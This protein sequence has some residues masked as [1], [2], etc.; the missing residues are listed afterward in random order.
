MNTLWKSAIELTIKKVLRMAHG[1]KILIRAANGTETE[2]DLTELAAINSIAAA[3]LAKIDGITNGTAAAGKALVL[4]ATGNIDTFRMTGKLFTPQAAPETATDT[5]TLTAAQ[6]LSGILV[7]TPTAA[8]AYT[9]LTGTQLQTALLLVHPNLTAGDCF[10]LTI[11]N[12]GGTGDDITL[13]APASGITIVGDAV[14]RPSADSATE[15]A[16]QG[17]FRFRYTAANTFVAY[18]VS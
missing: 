11:I 4:G 9:M 17:T 1:S 12:I 13:T 5:A 14:V 15:Q 18:R 10:D 2:I 8:A 3:D 16:G 7:A 6:H